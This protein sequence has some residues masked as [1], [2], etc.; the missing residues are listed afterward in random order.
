VHLATLQPKCKGNLCPLQTHNL[1]YIYS[2][3][4]EGM[5]WFFFWVEMQTLF[6]WTSHLPSVVKEC[7]NSPNGTK[8]MSLSS[9]LQKS[10]KLVWNP[11]CSLSDILPDISS[12]CQ[13]N[14]PAISFFP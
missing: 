14:R 7:C 11:G 9:S 1:S 4:C 12:A 5:G 2:Q 10:S 8:L 3:I 6:Q 13:H